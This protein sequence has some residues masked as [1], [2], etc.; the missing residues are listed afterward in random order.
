MY[1]KDYPMVKE[2]MKALFM[3]NWPCGD[4]NDGSGKTYK[5]SAFMI[6]PPLP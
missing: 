4:L 2:E 5:P 6:D 3:V 1:L